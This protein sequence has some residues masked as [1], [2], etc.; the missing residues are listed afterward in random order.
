[1]PKHSTVVAYV[2]L[3]IALGGTSYA[4][5]KLPK[6]SVGGTQIKANAVTSGKV[7]NGSLRKAD[8]KASDLPVGAAGA[9]GPQG[10]QGLKGDKGDPGTPGAQGPAGVVGAII[11]ERT[12]VN[13]PDGASAEAEATCPSGTKMISGGASTNATNAGN[14]PDD[15]K[16]LVSR[17][18][19]S[20]E[21]PT[22][23][24]DI[25]NTW[26]VVY[27]NTTGGTGAVTVRAHAN[28]AV[29]P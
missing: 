17:N 28:C 18:G 7:K 10:A 27:R 24:E 6:N 15:I 19:P 9:Q 23:G 16:L 3:F 12:D 14:S 13:L 5:V 22:D 25:T 2:A 26:R 29:L 1:M 20:T 21:N 11:A 8:F 4:A